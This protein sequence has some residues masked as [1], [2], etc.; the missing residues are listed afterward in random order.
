LLAF[1]SSEE[2]PDPQFQAPVVLFLA[3]VGEL[4]SGQEKESQPQIEVGDAATVRLADFR[5]RQTSA[6]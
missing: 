4:V 6:P 2:I 3:E 1:P 5:P